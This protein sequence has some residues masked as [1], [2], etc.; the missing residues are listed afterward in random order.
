M[1][2]IAYSVTFV[3]ASAIAAALTALRL[4]LSVVER[5]FGL[6]RPLHQG[7][8]ARRCGVISVPSNRPS[9]SMRKAD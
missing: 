8:A 6:I 3:L 1:F 4:V 5:A 9:P 7:N 2:W